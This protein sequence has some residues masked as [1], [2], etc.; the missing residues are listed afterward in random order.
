[1]G[2]ALKLPERERLALEQAAIIHQRS[3]L[4]VDEN[5]WRALCHELGIGEG[6]LEQDCEYAEVLKVLRVLHGKR[7]E[8]P[9][10]RKLATILEQC[11]DLDNAWELNTTVSADPDICGLDDVT[12]EV[13]AYLSSAAQS[14]FERA[15]SKVVVFPAVAGKASAMLM[16]DNMNLADL[17]SLVGSDQTL[18]GH[19]VAAAN[20]AALGR[21]I[22]ATTLRQALVH[23]GARVARQVIVASSLRPVFGARHSRALW[24]HSLDVAESAARM[25][26]HSRTVDADQAFLAGLVHDLGKLVLLNLPAKSMDRHA[27]LTGAGC[28]GLLV[29]Q[30]VFGRTHATVG[31]D[32]LRKWH[33][34]ENI[35]AAVEDHHEPERKAPEPLCCV[36]YLAESAAS[37]NE[38]ASSVWREELARQNVC[39]RSGSEQ[40]IPA[41]E[42]PLAPLRFAAAA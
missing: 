24:N 25:A 23:I 12:A 21:S 37:R 34:D 26:E 17:E 5:A 4:V 42:S 29:E 10:V 32:L 19:I 7:A 41:S 9:W 39:V 15:E 36:L 1:V 38:E 20:S 35:V 3:K 33:F 31:A 30:V 14:D 40:A 27:R 13:A 16:D 28:P 6:H 2:L 11:G 22:P 8:A 18:A